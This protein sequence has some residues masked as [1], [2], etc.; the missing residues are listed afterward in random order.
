VIGGWLPGEG[1]RAGANRRA[2]DGL[3]RGRPEL[4]FAGRVGTG[5][6]DAT[7][8]ELRGASRRCDRENPFTRARS[9]RATRSS[10]SRSWW[11]RSSSPNGPS[12]RGDARPVVQGPAR[13]QAGRRGRARGGRR[14]ARAPRRR[15]RRATRSRRATSSG[16][17]RTARSRS[18]TTAVAEALQLGQGPVPRTGFTKGDL[19]DYYARVAPAVL[20]HLRD[21]PLTLKRYPN[22]VEEPYFYEK[23]SPSH[24][25]EWVPTA[26]IGGV[27][28]TLAQERPTLVWLA[29]LA[30]IELHTSLALAARPSADDAGVRPRPR[31]AG[32][33][34][35]VLR[36]GA[37]AARPV[38]APR[39]PDV[40]KTSG[41]KGLQVYVPL[42][43]G[44]TTR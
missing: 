44:A 13:R 21:R 34:R 17:R 31:R 19:I 41:S 35:R 32:R 37:R 8:D 11:P 1:R 12:R 42:G 23:Q 26:R 30:D 16:E 20:P 15:R 27:D 14:S 40:V 7:L 29:N 6:T 38:R 5:F 18:S 39:T 22:G 28:Y 36:G 3:S 33:A 25:P 24:R 43:S 4:R 9:C 10:S 2:A